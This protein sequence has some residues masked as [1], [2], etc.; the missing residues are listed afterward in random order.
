MRSILIALF[1]VCGFPALA[2][3]CPYLNGSGDAVTFVD[4][5]E[6]TV[7][8]KRGGTTATCTWMITP[9]GP[10][11][12]DIACDDGTRAGYF[13][14]ADALGATNRNLLVFNEDVWFRR[15]G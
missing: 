10:D 3:N 5:G 2:A 8:L 9:D 6:N 7:T 4:D 13:F 1:L 11:A 14:A 12:A 15:C